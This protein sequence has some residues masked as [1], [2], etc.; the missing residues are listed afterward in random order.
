MWRDPKAD[1]EVRQNVYQP[2]ELIVERARRVR[3]VHVL[4]EGEVELRRRVDRAEQ[5]LRTIGAGSHF[6]RKSLEQAS[7]DVAV[8]K[9]VVRTIALREDQA[10]RL[11]DV[12]ISAER[13]V[14]KTG[15]YPIDQGQA[16]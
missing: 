16:G 4:L 11:Q 2:G 7:A 12:L 8:A 5:S 6:G 10:N 9:S 3:Y 15:I 13:I 14:A 1:Y